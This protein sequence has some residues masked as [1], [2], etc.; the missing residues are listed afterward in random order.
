MTMATRRGSEV[1]PPCRVA[2]ES[3]LNADTEAFC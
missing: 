2:S 1:A 3:P